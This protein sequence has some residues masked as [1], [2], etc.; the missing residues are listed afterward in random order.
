MK[1][2][3]KRRK[4]ELTNDLANQ[5]IS[6]EDMDEAERLANKALN[7][8]LQKC[9]RKCEDNKIAIK[10]KLDLIDELLNY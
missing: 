5:K 2:L 7:D 6:K 10:A 3:L 8:H 9:E 1:D 4:V